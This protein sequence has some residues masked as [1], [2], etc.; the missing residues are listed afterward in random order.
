MGSLA[1][2]A[3]LA[4]L[5]GLGALAALWALFLW[6]E[7]LLS[8]AGGTPFCALGDASDCA[9]VWNSAFASAVHRVSGVPVAGWGLVWGLVAGALPLAALLRAA[10]GRP[11][12]ALVSAVRLTAAAGMVTVFVMLAVSAA[13]QAFCGSCAVSYLLAAG[14]AGIALF[15]W[16][17]AGLPDAGRGLALAGGATLLA[18]ALLLYPGLRTP[19]GA[20]DAGREAVARAARSRSASAEPADSARSASLRELIASLSPEMKQTLSDSLHV[21]R[22]AATSAAPRPRALSGPAEAPVRIT[23]WT[24]VR[25]GH[26]ADLHE[27]LEALRAS[28]P[29]GSFSV[30]SRQFPLDAECNS[31]VG[32]KRDPV[33]CVAALARICL[34]G[35]E[36]AGA[37][38][39]ALF[40]RQQTLTREQVVAL[41]AA[42]M[43][44]AALEGCLASEATRSKLQDDIAFASRFEPD[45]TPIVAV[46]GRRGTSFAPFL[47]AMVLTGGE[48]ADPAFDALPPPNPAAHL[49]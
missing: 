40:A 7:L 19:R 48:D 36:G 27:T 21:Y 46:N 18:F 39:E 22:T 16:P 4:S 38:A 34:E 49:H 26:C 43:P 28:A 20:G 23:E 6:A 17:R 2:P 3:S 33:R 29:A 37:F 10:E 31:L 32:G 44:R 41:G 24:D 9:A 47:Y 25:C 45:G 30:D 35:K 12:P 5:V 42:H 13:A 15:G 14:Y 1:T 8:R 11:V